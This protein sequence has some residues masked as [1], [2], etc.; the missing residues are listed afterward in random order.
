MYKLQF[1][2]II[3]AISLPFSL[4]KW[5][6]TQASSVSSGRSILKN[7]CSQ[8]GGTLGFFN[9]EN[10][11]GG[12]PGEIPYRSDIEELPGKLLRDH[13]DQWSNTYGFPNLKL[14]LSTKNIIFA[15]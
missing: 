14:Y 1:F 11:G 7:K 4:A 2:L 10:L 15:E 9:C 5:L 3:L 8:L 6:F 12:G 13:S